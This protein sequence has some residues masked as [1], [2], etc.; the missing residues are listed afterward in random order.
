MSQPSGTAKLK[1]I[2]IDHINQLIS[3]AD[4]AREHYERLYGV[5]V[6]EIFRQRT[7][8]YDNFIVKVGGMTLEV[9]AP[10]DPEHSFGRQ[11]QR[12]GNCWQGCLL[13]VPDLVDAIDICKSHDIPVI[14]VNLERGWAFTDPR[15]TF[16]SIQLEDLDD[17][18]K[19]VSPN[20]AGIVGLNGFTVAVHD[21]P[22]AVRFFQDLVD[23]TELLYEEERPRL[24][25][26]ATGLRLGGYVLELQSPSGDGKLRN[27]LESYRQRIRSATW[28]VSDLDATSR[29][30]AG[31]DV[32][33]HDGDREG[34]L[35]IA[36]EDNLGI[37][38]Q[39]VGE[40]DVR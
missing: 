36:P 12:F 24:A 7:G 8:P 31:H 10:I 3:N 19:S 25:G 17:W 2:E 33:L 40:K 11:H 16:F 28:N 18:D 38:M 34:T 26:I 32:T 4:L 27:F 9:F 20:E 1:V 35:L 37:E 29:H 30:F 22:Q 13:R 39:F 21:S 14:D 6:A 23:D 5:R 15:A